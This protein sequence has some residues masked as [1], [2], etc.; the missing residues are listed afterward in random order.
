MPLAE[1]F[2]NYYKNIDIGNADDHNETFSDDFSLNDDNEILNSEITEN[3][4]LKCICYLKNGKAAGN[5][6]VINEYINVTSHLFIKLFNNIL[7]TEF[8][9]DDC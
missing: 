7:N 2:L 9:P 5:D 6:Q 8:I 4:I 3:E 1:C